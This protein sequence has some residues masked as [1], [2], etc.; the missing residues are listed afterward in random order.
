M[1][2]KEDTLFWFFLIGNYNAIHYETEKRIQ[3]IN[4]TL[5]TFFLRHKIPDT[6]VGGT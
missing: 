2:S 1:F 6:Y 3:Y 5:G 4:T